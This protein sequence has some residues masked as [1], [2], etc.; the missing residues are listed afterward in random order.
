MIGLHGWAFN[1]QILM[2]IPAQPEVPTIWDI[3]YRGRFGLGFQ[4]IESHLRL[5]FPSEVGAHHLWPGAARPAALMLWPQPG[6]P[7]AT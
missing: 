2:T 6:L 4:G 1:S 5:S 7:L 3:G